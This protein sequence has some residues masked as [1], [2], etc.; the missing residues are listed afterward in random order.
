[1]QC[2]YRYKQLQKEDWFDA[3]RALA[4]AKETKL[5]EVQTPKKKHLPAVWQ[6][7]VLQTRSVDPAALLRM[8]A[9]PLH[10]LGGSGLSQSISVPFQT[11]AAGNPTWAGVTAQSSAVE[12]SGLAL[13]ASGSF[14]GISPMGSLRFDR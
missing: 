13:S 6:P 2:R 12:F 11:P 10:S 4:Q 14:G 9:L 3:R 1:V 8:T 5:V 7:T